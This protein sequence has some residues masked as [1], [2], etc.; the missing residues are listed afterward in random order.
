MTYTDSIKKVL[1]VLQEQPL[2]L[3]QI[4]RRSRIPRY[5]VITILAQL[6]RFRIAHWEYADHQFLFGL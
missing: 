2:P 4:V 5:K 3:N 6:I 1:K